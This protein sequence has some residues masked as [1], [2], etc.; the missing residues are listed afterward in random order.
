M[1]MCKIELLNDLSFTS[2]TA[3]RHSIRRLAPNAKQSVSTLGFESIP[4]HDEY[5]TEFVAIKKNQK[6]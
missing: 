6:R 3:V 2:R 4:S 5:L 1:L